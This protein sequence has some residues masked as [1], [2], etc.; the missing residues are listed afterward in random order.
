MTSAAV[1]AIVLSALQAPDTPRPGAADP[2]PT[3]TLT[4]AQCVALARRQA[5]AAVA[6]GLEERA[7]AYDLAAARRNRRPDL[8]LAGGAWVAPAWSY[9]PAITN[10]GEYHAQVGLELPLADGGRRARERARAEVD[11]HGAAA[12]RVL[13]SRDAG[14]RAAALAL[15]CVRIAETGG[16]LRDHR[17][18]L[19]DIGTLVRAGVRA[20]VRSPADSIRLALAEGD[21]ALDLASNDEQAATARLELLEAL[22]RPLDRDIVVRADPATPVQTPDAADSLVLAAAAARR[23][24]L[25]LARADEALARL[26]EADAARAAAPAV[27]LSVDAGLAGSDLTRAV[28][29]ALLAEQPNAT[30]RDR[31]RRDLGASA[32]LDVRLPLL[33]RA[34]PLATSARTLDLHAAEQRRAAEEAAGAREAGTLLERARSAARRLEI[35]EGV[36]ER[37]EAHVLRTKSLYAAGAT[38]LFDLLDALDLDRDARVRRADVRE[39]YR[40]SRFEIED[41]R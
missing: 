6:A 2:A 18:G 12:R 34:R 39:E 16:L 5:P 13:A 27:N 21:A 3:E 23:P 19:A 10:L 17:A 36:V 29:S 20:G 41:R 35:A 38:T 33:D 26:A 8:F 30:F 37:A 11:A 32:A 22:A 15:E 40:M 24:E 1:L 7:A 28:P 31:L 4:V 25:A 9:D 14:E